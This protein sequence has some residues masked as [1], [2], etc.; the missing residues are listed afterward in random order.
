MAEPWNTDTRT[1][2][3]EAANAAYDKLS[4]VVDCAE[5]MGDQAACDLVEGIRSNLADLATWLETT[6]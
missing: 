3:I 1:E 4:D 6:R 2:A 5:E